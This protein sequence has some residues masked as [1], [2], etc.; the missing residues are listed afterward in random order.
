MMLLVMRHGEAVS[1]ASSDFERPLTHRG[2][3]QVVDNFNKFLNR[4]KPLPDLIF[5]SPLVRARQTTDLILDSSGIHV[6]PEISDKP[7]PEGRVDDVLQLLATNA[8]SNVCLLVSH[9]PLVSY[10]VHCLTD[11]EVF[12]ET[13]MIVG[14]QTELFEPHCGEVKWHINDYS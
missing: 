7:V 6:E 2:K 3:Q 12:L 14:I 5:T 1:Q 8:D 11:V 13:S 10:L 9:Q 4:Q